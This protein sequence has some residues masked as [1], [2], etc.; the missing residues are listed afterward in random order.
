VTTNEQILDAYIRHQIYILRYAGGLRNEVVPFL[1]IT[2]A[3]LEEIILA[4]IG[5]AGENRILTGVKGRKWQTEFEKALHSLRDPAW[6]QV[7]QNI[8]DEMRAFAV[9]EAAAGAAVIEGAVPVILNL[10]LPPVAQL[11]GIV[12]SQP[13]EGRTLKK[14]LEKNKMDDV[15]RILTRAKIG[16]VQGQT[17][18]QIAADI[19]GE[20][21]IGT[22]AYR[23]I[24]S[25][26]LT[27]TNGIQQEA[28]QALYQA[29]QDIIKTELFVAT[30]DSRTTMVCMGN[31]GKT[32]KRGD[33]PIPPLHFRCR[34][35]R[36]PVINAKNLG[37][38]PYNSATEKQLVTDYAEQNNLGKITRVADLPMEHEKRYLRFARA[39]MPKYVGTV[40]ATTS[41]NTWLKR[42]TKDFQDDVLGPSRAKIFR[43]GGV[44]L[45][46]FT[47][48]SGDMLTLDELKKK[49]I[50]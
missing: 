1:H 20:K 8:I 19:V 46:R 32:F 44:S 33:G 17:P 49:G 21:K 5:K 15:Q 26:L 38:R 43:K 2:D 48:R 11:V 25:V 36:V 40:P 6:G 41:Y 22:K 13:F 39:E 4:Y 42:Q 3:R 27:L 16:I 18:T 30:L 47:A 7:S 9:N 14:W 12:N 34:S 45:D 10:S 31:D 50:G 29:N 24:E 28:K 35:L 23:D 37:D